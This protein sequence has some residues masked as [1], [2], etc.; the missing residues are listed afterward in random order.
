MYGLLGGTFDPPHFGH[1]ALADTAIRQLPIPEVIFAPAGDPWQKADTDVSPARERL[2]MTHLA[3]AEDARFIVTD[4]EVHRSGPSFTIDTVEELGLPST[5]I[6]GSDAAAGIPTW[7]RG[8]DLLDLV[9]VAVVERPGT[10]FADV[11]E[12]IGK[13]IMRLDMAPVGISSTEIRHHVRRGGSPRFLV[14]DP[15]AEYI[16]TNRL[17]R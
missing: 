3:A 13:T 15:I 7:H 8:T 9:E 12:A 10:S 6:L 16:V 11:E 1:L 17:Y 14:P 2:A 4:I 5:L